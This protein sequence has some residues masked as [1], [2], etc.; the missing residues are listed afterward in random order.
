ME[1]FL[2]RATC[3]AHLTLINLSNFIIK[4]SLAPLF[5]MNSWEVLHFQINSAESKYNVYA[6]YRQTQFSIRWYANLLN[7]NLNYMFRP[8][9]LAII[10]LYKRKLIK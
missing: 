2:V 6:I 10:R 1:F 4:I 9:S 5:S 8:Q 3:S 7:V